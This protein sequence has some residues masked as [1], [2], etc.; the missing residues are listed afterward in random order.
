MR[1]YVSP[2]YAAAEGFESGVNLGIKVRRA[3]RED[4]EYDQQQKDKAEDRAW[5]RSER[6]RLTRSHARAEEKDVEDREH[7]QGKREL[8]A[9]E[10]ERTQLND[11]LTS[12]AQRKGG[13]NK[14]DPEQAALTGRISQVNQR[15]RQALERLVRPQ[16]ERYQRLAREKMSKLQSD[17]TSI[18]SW[19]DDDTYRIFF[20]TGNRDPRDF[21]R[22]PN[23]E[24]S[25]IGAAIQSI[26][27]GFDAQDQQ[28]V[29]NGAAIILEPELSVG[30]GADV[31]EGGTITGKRLDR[32]VPSQDGQGYH[33]NLK[34][35]VK[36]PDGSV[37][38]RDAPVTEGRSSDPKARV[39]TLDPAK[40]MD[41]LGRMK[42]LE[43]MLNHPE[44]R[45]KVERGATK[46]AQ[47]MGDFWK[48]ISEINAR[49]GK[50]TTTNIQA[51]DRVV[52]QTRNEAGQTVK[53]S[54][55]NRGTSPDAKERTTAAGIRSSGAGQGV[56]H[57]RVLVPTGEEDEDGNPIMEERFVQLPTRAGGPA[58]KV[59]ELPDRAKPAP[60]RVPGDDKPADVAKAAENEVSRKAGTMGL[61]WDDASKRWKSADGKPATQD[62]VALLNEVRAAALSLGKKSKGAADSVPKAKMSD[63][64]VADMR[65]KAKKAIADGKDKAAVAKRF[66]EL[67]GLKY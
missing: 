63:A 1:G 2:G 45:A 58:P 17:P 51:G 32:F 48:Q 7:T 59:V 23:G 61:S 36:Q 25:K 62:Q 46:A 33:V 16:D 44:V 4:K 47:E 10:L 27:Q 66:E 43:E 67:T 11:Q 52:Q 56:R 15:R 26:E 21:L 28:S 65:A 53:E 8:E 38:T 41:R 19:S 37:V 50:F 13:F 57:D 9:V 6:D 12:I 55:I 34:V 3:E 39:V 49:P 22:G 29:V 5:T 20:T 18:A 14:D 60:K 31:P 64:E 40:M 42:I 35:D 54:T 30:I 24:P